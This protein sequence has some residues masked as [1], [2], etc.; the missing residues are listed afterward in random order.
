MADSE[1][2]QS[3]AAPLLSRLGARAHDVRLHLHL[4]HLAEELDALTPASR[5]THIARGKREVVW[6]KAALTWMLTLP[7]L[8][9]DGAVERYSTASAIFDDFTLACPLNQPWVHFDFPLGE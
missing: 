3:S 4:L 8:T 5:S 2:L 7:C 1:P 6:E 9:F